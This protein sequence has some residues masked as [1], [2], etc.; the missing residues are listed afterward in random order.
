MWASSLS[1][2]GLSG[3]GTDGGDW[4]TH[5]MEHELSGMFDV[6]HGAG[7]TAIW[8]SWA[9]YVCQNR[10]DR[11]MHFALRAMQVGPGEGMEQTALRGIQAMEDFF[12]SI[13]LP[14]SLSELGISPTDEQLEQMAESCIQ[15]VG[16]RHLGTV[17]PLTAQDVA[18]IY[19][20]A[21]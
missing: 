18:A 21:R 11:F 9:R 17:K 15:A 5:K 4:A 14:T 1:H 7:L 12:R 13:G 10:L 3:F 8:G 19:R 6:A 20:M 2:N 16:G